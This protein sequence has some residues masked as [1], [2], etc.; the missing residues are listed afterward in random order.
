MLVVIDGSKALRKAVRDVLGDSVV[1]QRCRI[2]KMRNVLDHLPKTHHLW[3]QQ[4]L[5][6]A[7]AEQDAE[8]AMAA[9]KRL[10]DS[11][12]G[13]YPGAAASIREGLEETLTVT[14]LGLTGHLKRILSSTNIIESANSV[15]QGLAKRVKRWRDTGQI[16]RWTAAG[17]LDAEKRFRRIQGYQQLPLLKAALEREVHRERKEMVSD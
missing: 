16:L 3:V 11:L 7:W 6:A 4:R 5:R 8:K 14:R 17:L 10:A 9:L 2:H 1:V 13:E 12:E 15:A